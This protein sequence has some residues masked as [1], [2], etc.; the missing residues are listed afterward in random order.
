MSA[1]RIKRASAWAH[2][3]GNQEAHPVM[4]PITRDL[5]GNVHTPNG[6]LPQSSYEI[7]RENNPQMNLP[8]LAEIPYKTTILTH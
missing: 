7:V 6:S 1:K 4:H 2:K 5:A 3:G 8:P